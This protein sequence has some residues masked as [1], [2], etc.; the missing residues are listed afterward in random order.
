M[1][2]SLQSVPFSL[3]EGRFLDARSVRKRD[4]LLGREFISNNYGGGVVIGYKN[5]LSVLFEFY[6]PPYVA[7]FSLSSLKTGCFKNPLFRSVHGVGCLGVGKYSPKVDKKLYKLWVGM[8]ER[9]CCVKFKEEYPTYKDVTVCEEW[10]DFQNFA[11][12]CEAQEHFF[13]KDTRGRC[14]QL[15]K[16]ILVK[17]NKQYSAETCCFVPKDINL[18]LLRNDG[19]RGTLPIGVVYSRCIK[20]FISQGKCCGKSKHIGTFKTPEE[21]FLA[22]KEAK[23]I[24]V[25]TVAEEY[26][27]VMSGVVYKAL[28]EYKVDVDD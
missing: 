15:D 2:C 4:E 11:A 1:G 23:E 9:A 6:D 16:D 21:A 7:E 14:Y 3:K 22:Y 19:K 10:L 8:L 17:G 27:S 12:W 13:Y 20:R 28:L 24:Y 25:K 26:K 18:L 5:S